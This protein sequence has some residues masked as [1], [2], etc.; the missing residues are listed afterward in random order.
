MGLQSRRHEGA[1][2]F[3]IFESLRCLACCCGLLRRGAR[4]SL[5]AALLAEARL[6]SREA[7]FAQGWMSVRLHLRVAE[8][9]QPWSS[10]EER[11]Q[12]FQC[13]GE[14]TIR[15]LL[16]A[17][18]RELGLRVDISFKLKG[19]GV[20]PSSSITILRDD[21][22][23]E[24]DVGPFARCGWRQPKAREATLRC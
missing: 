10:V 18:R 16:E 21:D 19:S 6:F 13:A 4:R 7:Q 8:A 5:A 24:V 20:R 23:L 9:L 15:D 3:A 12:L 11:R 1:P 22:V 2:A 17:V 14:E